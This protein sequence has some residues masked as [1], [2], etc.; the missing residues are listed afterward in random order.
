MAKAF[1]V[2]E[3]IKKFSS[4][5]HTAVPVKLL[6]GPQIL[7]REVKT[8]KANGYITRGFNPFLVQLILKSD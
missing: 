1:P 7:N 4:N 8:T 6:L 3:I 2:A 5:Q